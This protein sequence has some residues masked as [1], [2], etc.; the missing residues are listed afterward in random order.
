[1]AR[2]HKA[3]PGL[4]VAKPCLGSG[5]RFLR[6]SPFPSRPCPNIQRELFISDSVM[7]QKVSQFVRCWEILAWWKC[8]SY[9]ESILTASHSK[10]VRQWGEFTMQAGKAASIVCENTNN[11]RINANQWECLSVRRSQAQQCTSASDSNDGGVQTRRWWQW[12]GMPDEAELWV[13][14]KTRGR[15]QRHFAKGLLK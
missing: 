4:A 7:L 2:K 6:G 11:R 8:W 9:C 13:R 14:A 5:P 10:V 1:M 15:L 3:L 12:A